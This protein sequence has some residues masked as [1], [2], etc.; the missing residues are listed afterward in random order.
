MTD[1]ATPRAPAPSEEVLT[2]LGVAIVEDLGGRR[3]DRWLAMSGA[4]PVVLRR[5]SA[6]PFGDISY[7]LRVLG[8]MRK[9][10]WPVPE[11]ITDAVMIDGRVWCL[12]AWLPGEPREELDEEA[13][14][15]RG[16]LLAVLHDD[17]E[18]LNVLGQRGGC[19]EA[20]EV[21]AD[22]RL[23]AGL[24]AYERWF[25]DESAVMRWHV[26]RARELF[27]SVD[28]RLPRRVVLHSDLTPWNVL[29]EGDRLTGVIDFEATH[30][31]FA[32]ADFALAWRGDDDA[33]IEGYTSV[34]ALADVERE[35]IAPVFWAW[36]FLG[37][38]D[39]LDEM[40]A[41]TIEPAPLDWTVSNLLK[42]S[43]WMGSEAEPWV[44]P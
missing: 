25:P 15:D 32:V 4:T 3:D 7:E 13:T 14:R 2:C 30:R 37:V 17:L 18:A 6:T 43:R 21:I 11:P 1:S 19:S 44:A 31:N 8:H 42:R 36:M 23:D 28:L 26:D 38:A 20:H 39:R 9:R 12:F 40:A 16:R 24:S 34:R 35:I 27:A 41:G 10:G 5:F 22:P 33:V 29:Y